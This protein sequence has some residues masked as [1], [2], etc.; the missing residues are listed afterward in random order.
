MMDYINER[1]AVEPTEKFLDDQNHANVEIF[2]HV[3]PDGF[4]TIGH[5][6]ICID[7]Q[8]ISYG[9]YD[10]DSIRLF[11]TIG[12][13]VL[14]I[15]PRESYIPFCIE[16]DH[17]TIFSYGVR[18]TVKQLASVKRE[19]EKLKENTYPWYPRSYKDRNDCND[20]ASR[21]YLRTGASF[22]KFK[23]GRYKTYFVLGSNCVKLAEAIM[24]KA[25][26][27]I[28]D[29]NGIISRVLIKTI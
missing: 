17:K 15:A 2:I 25:G 21:L 29:L 22:F 9:N 11:E 8:V 16:T 18:L 27:D 12:D 6:D 10:Y 23:R 24:G 19:I 28:I 14:F 5:C 20:Y 7:N 4:G 26:M 13:G 3:S 1:L